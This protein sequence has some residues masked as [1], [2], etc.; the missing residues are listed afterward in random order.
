[1]L[2]VLEC[3]VCVVCVEN[4]VCHVLCCS[5]LRGAFVLC[6]LECV[7]CVESYVCLVCVANCGEVHWCCVCWKESR[8]A[9]VLCV[10]E[11][12]ER[13]VVVCVEV[14]CLSRNVSK[15]VFCFVYVG[16]YREVRWCCLCWSVVL[17]VLE[18]VV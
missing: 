4:C 14:C 7:V 13:C 8:G 18:C 3:V 5:V 17:F 16:M 15:G 12:M 2:C 11:N 6:V 10:L 9:W 1:M